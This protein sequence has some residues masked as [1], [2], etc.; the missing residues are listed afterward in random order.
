MIVLYLLSWWMIYGVCQM[1]MIAIEGMRP[2][3]LPLYGVT[4]WYIG[5][6]VHYCIADYQEKRK[7]FASHITHVNDAWSRRY[8]QTEKDAFLSERYSATSSAWLWV[9]MF[10]FLRKLKHINWQVALPM[11][12]R[13][14]RE[15]PRNR[16]KIQNRSAMFAEER[17]SHWPDRHF[18]RTDLTNRNLL[19]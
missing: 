14:Q 2:V 8:H 19:F 7:D 12:R 15:I 18:K 1:Q 6:T 4:G 13:I 10:W 17:K 11:A 16:A 9:S 5:F 3:P